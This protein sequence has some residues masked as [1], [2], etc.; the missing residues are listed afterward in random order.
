MAK[1]DRKAQDKGA[2]PGRDVT[3]RQVGLEEAATELLRSKRKRGRA[4]RAAFDSEE[5]YRLITE[6]AADAMWTVDMD[7]RPTYISP[8]ITPLLGYSVQEAMAK[9]MQEIFTAASFKLATKLLKEEIGRESRGQKDLAR[10]RTLEVELIRKD[11]SLVPV[12]VKYTFLHDAQARPVEILAIARDISER[13]KAQEEARQS[14]EKLIRAMEHAIQAMTIVVEMRDPHTAGHQQRATQLACAI[15]REIGLS[16]E[17]ISGL[18]LAGLIHDIGKVRVPA[19]IL[20]NPDGLSEPEFMMIKAHPRLGYEILKTIDF[21]WPVAQ[22]VLQHHERMDGSGYPS[23]LSGED[24]VMEARILAVADVVDAMASH[25]PYRPALGM[26]KALDEI[27][28]NRGVLYDSRVVDACLTLFRDK[29]FDFEPH[30]K[31]G[32]SLDKIYHGGLQSRPV[33]SQSGQQSQAS[34]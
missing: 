29:N 15:A 3:D 21:P 6:R 27:S 4:G 24:I 31:V 8:S 13:K 34:L 10:A 25:R 26:S 17:Q 28:Q 19:E 5:R 12:E 20:M 1:L 11:G 9:S 16:E 30:T 23:G 14:I 22:I 18:R 7:M 2:G 33:V 32:T